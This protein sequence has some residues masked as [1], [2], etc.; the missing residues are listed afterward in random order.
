M[1]LVA[2]AELAYQLQTSIKKRNFQENDVKLFINL[3][4]TINALYKEGNDDLSVIVAL[5]K[6]IQV[7]TPEAREIYLT[8]FYDRMM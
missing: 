5:I 4:S 8:Q 6:D 7:L 3:M 1:I 2:Y